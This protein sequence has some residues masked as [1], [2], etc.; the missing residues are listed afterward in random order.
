[1]LQ[2]PLSLGGKVLGSRHAT[3]DT[4]QNATM[5]INKTGRGWKML[6]HVFLS[7]QGSP[8][9]ASHGHSDYVQVK[10]TPFQLDLIKS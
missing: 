10:S 2:A 6:S 9:S 3:L 5:L 4:T 7:Q 1:M 8:S